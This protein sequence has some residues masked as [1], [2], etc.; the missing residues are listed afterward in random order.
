MN[1]NGKRTAREWKQKRQENGKRT[2]KEWKHHKKN[3]TQSRG[4]GL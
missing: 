1:K 4:P 3:I 2:E